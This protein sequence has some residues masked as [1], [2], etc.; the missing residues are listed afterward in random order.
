MVTRRNWQRSLEYEQNLKVASGHVLLLVVCCFTYLSLYVQNFLILSTKTLSLPTIYYTTNRLIPSQPFFAIQITILHVIL[1]Q[2][3][4]KEFTLARI[5]HLLQSTPSCKP[6]QN[7][8]DPGNEKA[9]FYPL[10]LDKT[11]QVRVWK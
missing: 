1:F 6:A 4:V 9:Y 7:S 8:F 10:K 2:S 3:Y 11:F 5:T